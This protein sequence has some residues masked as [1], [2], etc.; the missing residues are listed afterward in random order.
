MV[1]DCID[2]NPPRGTG[3]RAW[4]LR[5]LVAAAPAGWWAEYTGLPPRELL[6]LAAKSEWASALVLGWT[7]SAVRD[8]EPSWIAALLDRPEGADREVF[9]ALRPADR[10]RWLRERPGSALLGWLDLVPAP[11]SLQLSVV[12]RSWVARLAVSDSPHAPD[13][14][15][16]MRLAA[17][18]LDPPAAPELEQ[19]QVHPRLHDSWAQMLGTL[20]TR[21]AMRRELAEEP[22]P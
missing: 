13:A 16:L 7:D 4:L 15:R 12:A 6:S 14:R 18:R 20:S 21:A 8:G 19:I 10:D 17:M 3:R 1:A 5:Q 11:W 2:Q 9:Q 22:T